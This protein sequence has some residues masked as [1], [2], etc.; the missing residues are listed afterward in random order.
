MTVWIVSFGFT[1]PSV[2]PTAPRWSSCYMEARR[3]WMPSREHELRRF[4]E[5]ILGPQNHDV[6]GTRL[7]WTFLQRHRK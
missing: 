2:C 3:A 6:E 7:A 5:R 4:V 1:F